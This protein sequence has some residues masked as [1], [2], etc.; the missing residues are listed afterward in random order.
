MNEHVTERQA[1][2]TIVPSGL[3][4]R[5]PVVAVLTLIL[6]L[7]FA[8]RA[9]HLDYQSFWS[10]EGI[11]LQRSAQPL[12]TL[13]ATM[14]VEHLPGYFVLLHFWL[15]LTGTHDFA[16]RFLSI[17]PSVLSIVLVYRLAADLGNRRVGLVVALLLATSAFQVWYA[18]EV[19]TYSWLLAASLLA[20]WFFWRLLTR[21]QQGRGY[22]VGYILATT[23]TVYLHYYGFL[24][25]F[26]HTCFAVG[27]VLWQR[28]WRF[29]RR[30][31]LGGIVSA[32][33]FAP[34]FPHALQIFSF[35][36][37]REPMDPK[38][39]PWVILT[40]YTVSNTL[41]LD[42]QPWLP[43]LYLGLIGVGALLWLAWRRAAGLFLLTCVAAPLVVLLVLI[44]RNPDFHERYAMTISAPLLILAAAPVALLSRPVQRWLRAY[45]WLA[46]LSAMLAM[47]LLVVLLAG[48][49]KALQAF[50]T[51]PTLQKPDFRAVAQTIAAFGKPG[52]IVLVDGPDPSLV[53]L[54]YYTQDYPVHDLRFLL[55]ADEA[56]ID[57]TLT[58]LTAQAQRVWEVLYFHEPWRV[59]AWLARR[60]WTSPPSDHN[61]IRLTLYGLSDEALVAQPLDLPVGPALQLTQV[62]VPAQAVAAGE[63]VRVST[64]WQVLAPPP[65]YKFSLRLQKPDGQVVAAQDYAP[66]NWFTP[67]NSWP[68][69]AEVVE[70]RAFFLPPDFAPGLY[71]ITLRLY[72]PATGAVAETP[73]GQ[74]IGLGSVTVGN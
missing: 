20:T 69:G 60:G 9:Y 15:S 14:P 23:L 68:V 11:S 4:G 56:T 12:P 35:T 42:W 55:Q 33:L 3:E 38:S 36:G 73:L 16:L 53:F 7:A 74:D 31:V 40:A 39:I 65:D 45:R 58:A 28:D 29:G 25:P 54:H 48:N 52:D 43:W 8:L 51:D 5:W 2:P 6:L 19:R 21:P 63:L 30:W 27:W 44:L 64:Y 61:G 13:L 22:L 10:D 41:P 70:R 66:H 47:L 67:T 59:Q 18:Q 57:Q 1:E 72:E 49:A 34:W 24:T 32:L 71:Q 37:W 17:W 26:A 46:A 62:M 50:Y